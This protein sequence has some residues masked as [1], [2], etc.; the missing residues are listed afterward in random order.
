M[1]LNTWAALYGTD[2]DAAIAGDV[3]M[4]ENDVTPTLKA[5]RSHGLDVVAIYNHMSGTQLA[6]HLH[7]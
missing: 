2:E 1:E 6:R 3:A 5:I 4:L 7:Y